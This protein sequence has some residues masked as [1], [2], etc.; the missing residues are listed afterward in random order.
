MTTALTPGARAAR[1]VSIAPNARVRVRRA[2]E[3]DVERPGELDV[4]DVAA[5]PPHEAG[6]LEPLQT[7]PDVSGV[8]AHGLVGGTPGLR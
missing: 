1:V 2:H 8:H 4:V 5:A 6:V 7:L 3:G